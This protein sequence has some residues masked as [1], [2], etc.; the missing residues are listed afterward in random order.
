MKKQRQRGFTLIELLVVIAIIAILIALLLPAVQQAR[1][2]AR[3]SQC[4]NNLKQIGLALHNYHDIHNVFPPGHT[5]T[6]Q[7]TNSCPEGTCGHWGWGA[8][9]LPMIDQAPLYNILQVDTLTLPQAT[10]DPNILAEMQ[11]PLA[12]FRCPSDVGPLR[13][14]EQKLPSTGGGGGDCTGASCVEVATSN[15]VGVN[16]SH[17]LDRNLWNGTFGRLPRLG[18]LYGGN[19][20]Y[21]RCKGVTDITDGT[22]NTLAI[23]E[24]AYQLQQT[25]L[26]AGVIYG[27]NGDTGNHNHQGLVYV[28]GAGRWGINDTCGDCSRAFSSQHTGGAQFVMA[29]GSVQFISENIDHNPDAAVNS[30]YEKL[31]AVDD[32]LAVGEF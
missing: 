22:S 32:G 20:G 4:K 29:D 3:R 9:I 25:I 17:D 28:T 15:Y 11:R 8:A 21:A 7:W 19:T 5:A 31:I 10:S 23:G 27:T 2:A 12:A 24:R 18:G 6:D 1:E 13:N 14:P 30:T 26:Q 16:D